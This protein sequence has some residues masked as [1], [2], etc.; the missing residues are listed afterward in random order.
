MM[1]ADPT[2]VALEQA[3]LGAAEA[4]FRKA[5]ERQRETA[6]ANTV[7]EEKHGRTVQVR[8]GEAAVAECLAEIFDGLADKMRTMA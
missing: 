4:A 6:Q 3:M 1:P 2:G 5:A 7:T 8:S